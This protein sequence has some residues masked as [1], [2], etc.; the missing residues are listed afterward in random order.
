MGGPMAGHIHRRFGPVSVWNRSRAVAERHAAEH[1]THFVEDIKD[2]RTPVVFCCLPTS[3]EVAQLVERLIQAR[4]SALGAVPSSPRAG[5]SAALLHRLRSGAEASSADLGRPSSTH[6]GSPVELLVDC[7][8]GEHARTV[9][10]GARLREH[11][12]EMVDCPVSGGPRGAQAASVTAMV[13]GDVPGYVE[14]AQQLASSFASKVQATGPLGSAHAVKSI[15]NILNSANLAAA[16]EGLLVLK[17]LFGDRV[18]I[19]ACLEC[20][21]TSSGRSLQSQVRIPEEVLSRRFGYGFDLQL[22][23]KDCQAAR[24]LLPAGDDG[25]SI[26][27]RV[28][29]VVEDAATLYGAECEEARSRGDIVDYTYVCKYLEDKEGVELRPGFGV[30]GK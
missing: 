30:A 25:A 12:I 14:V 27:T 13:G 24:A 6:S 11:G 16:T 7:T 15:N 22:M 29:K 2:L 21:N 26:L 18:D 23:H 4:R 17:R 20:I 9:E 28:A 19:G 5:P 1:G 3:A 8:S 10:I